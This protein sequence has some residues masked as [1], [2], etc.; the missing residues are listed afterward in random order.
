[1][2]LFLLFSIPVFYLLFS[3]FMQY[4]NKNFTF[5]FTA[6]IKG[7]TWFFPSLLIFILVLLF[8][9]VSYKP[10]NY[11][12]YYFLKD[13]FL[14]CVLAAG[15]YFVF[16]GFSHPHQVQN[17]F[18]NLFSFFAAF[19]SFIA[20]KDFFVYKSEYNFYL[21]FILPLLRLFTVLILS[22]LMEKFID[23]LGPEKILFGVL[24]F[25]VPVSAGFVS[26]FYNLNLSALAFLLSFALFAGAVAA[27]YFLKDL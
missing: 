25:F 7:I 14:L 19:F 24:M 18:L 13:H 10:F 17:P 23:A 9:P 6:I 5:T 15:G 2:T 20:I 1:M 22:F 11:Y 16:H 26:F 8:F 12:F 3:V 27:S 4:E 21:L